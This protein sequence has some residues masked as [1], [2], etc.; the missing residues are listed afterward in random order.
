[1]SIS[2]FHIAEIAGI[3]DWQPL[4]LHHGPQELLSLKDIEILPK[5]FCVI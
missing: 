2:F 5:P 3:I 4:C 1:V